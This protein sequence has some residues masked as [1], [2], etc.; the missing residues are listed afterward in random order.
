M[1]FCCKETN[2]L[3]PCKE[4]R[5]KAITNN[6]GQE[7]H[8]HAQFYEVDETKECVYAYGETINELYAN[9][10]IALIER[11]KGVVPAGKIMGELKINN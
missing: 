2:I 9:F 10:T 4:A 6:K 7:T 5:K 11:F 3:W 1:Y 8:S